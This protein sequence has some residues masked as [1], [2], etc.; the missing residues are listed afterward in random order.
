MVIWWIK[1]A[2]FQIGT[3]INSRCTSL[4]IALGYDS[5]WRKV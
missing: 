5:I 1:K 4:K 2:D 3:L